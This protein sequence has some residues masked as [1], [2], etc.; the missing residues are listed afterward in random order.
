MWIATI[1]SSFG[2]AQKMISSLNADLQSSQAALHTHDAQKKRVLTFKQA[3][4]L[5]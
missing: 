2:A 5:K 3:R 1:K 4:D